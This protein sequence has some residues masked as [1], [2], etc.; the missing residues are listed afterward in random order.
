MANAGTGTPSGSSAPYYVANDPAGLVGA[1]DTIIKG[2][3]NCR[4]K[5]SGAVAAGM[6]STGI[7]TL[8]GQALIFGDP[9]GWTLVDALTLELEGSA[10]ATFK[11][12]DQPTLEA[13]FACGGIIN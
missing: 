3:R 7:V 4:F 2:V 6:E 12:A 5:L 13:S 9:N 8:D 1:F 10:C 11:E